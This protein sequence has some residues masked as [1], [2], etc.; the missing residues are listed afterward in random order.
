MEKSLLKCVTE[1]LNRLEKLKKNSEK[2]NDELSRNLSDLTKEYYDIEREVNTMTGK[3]EKNV[4]FVVD[5][6]TV[7]CQDEYDNINQAN[8]AITE[9]MMSINAINNYVN[10]TGK[11]SEALKNKITHGSDDI[12]IQNISIGLMQ[13]HPEKDSQPLFCNFMRKKSTDIHQ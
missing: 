2:N 13:F 9:C 12:S 3:I 4:N 8:D 6:S 10:S 5:K 7:T 11:I 1:F